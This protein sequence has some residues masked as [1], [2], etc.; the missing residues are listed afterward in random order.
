MAYAMRTLCACVWREAAQEAAHAADSRAMDAIPAA[1]AEDDAW[2]WITPGEH[3]PPAVALA[4][5]RA[6]CERM[7]DLHAAMFALLGTHQG[8][9]REILAAALLQF[10]ADARSWKAD[11]LVALMTAVWTGG[12]EGFDAVSRA[13]RKGERKAVL[14][15]WV[16]D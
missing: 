12:K 7:P 15:A 4:R 3:G 16:K 5:L 10:R 2:R 6:I 11:D 8:L 13:R 1:A 9:P 14:G